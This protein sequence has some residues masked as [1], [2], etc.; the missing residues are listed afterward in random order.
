MRDVP[1]SCELA[2]SAGAHGGRA[3]AKNQLNPVLPARTAPAI[4]RICISL[5]IFSSEEEPP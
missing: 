4:Q 3:F 5:T 2:G 1:K